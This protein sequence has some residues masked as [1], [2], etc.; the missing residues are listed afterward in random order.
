MMPSI[1]HCCTLLPDCT[2]GRARQESK[3]L[4]RPTLISVHACG[5]RTALDASNHGV[6]N[7]AHVYGCLSALS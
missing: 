1:E 7:T 6:A 4:I 5:N 3:C 2:V